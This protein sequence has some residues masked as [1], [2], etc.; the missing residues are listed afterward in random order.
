MLTV[1]KLQQPLSRTLLAL[2][3]VLA[4]CSTQRKTERFLNKQLEYADQGEQ[5]TGLLMVDLSSRD[6]LISW[7][8]QRYFTPAS[9]MKVFTLYAALK[10]LP[11]QV[12]ALK[13]KTAGDTLHVLGTGDPSALHP[14][15]GDRTAV[16]F[17]SRSGHVVF[18]PGTMTEAAWGPGWAWDDF[19]SYYM[20]ERASLPIHGNVVRMISAGEALQVVP[21]IF[22]D[23]VAGRKEAFRRSPDKNLFFHHNALPDTVDVPIKLTPG[24]TLRLWEEAVGKKLTRGERLPEGS[25][26]RLPG[27]QSDTLYREMMTVSDNFLAEQLMLMVSSTLGDSL[28]FGKARDH[29]METYLAGM[30][31]PPRWVDG[32]GLSR[33]NL[34]TPESMVYL[35]FRLY[36]EIPEDRLFSLLAQGGQE[37]TLQ[38]WYRDPD[39]P[40]LFGKT[41]SLSNNHNLCGY[42]R[43]RSG[44]TVAFSFMNNHYRKPTEL[45][46]SRMQRILTWVRDHY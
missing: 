24:L 9:N 21:E 27:L 46:K 35:L 36:L 38:E 11:A 7:N 32:S 5:F 10:T 34:V 29:I 23:S 3:I 41:G 40:F 18:Y 6:T 20:P 39:G 33:Y 15:F 42:L 2:C 14:V 16:D 37:G 43:T 44:K 4:S 12:P 1:N 8:H 31:S 25:W 22:S 28:S 30:P 13:Y 19:D 17:I 45:V 26:E